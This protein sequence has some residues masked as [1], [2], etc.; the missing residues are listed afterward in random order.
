MQ[1]SMKATRHEIERLADLIDGTRRSL[2]WSMADLA[3]RSE[4]HES[5]VSRICRG[6]F[7]TFGGNVVQIC[8]ALNI[9]ATAPPL[10]GKAD[11]AGWALLEAA[12]R[13]AWDRT[14]EGAARLVKVIE[15]VAGIVGR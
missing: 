11:E 15:A 3:R 9:A 10:V 4:V 13:K 12:L 14:P 5:Q 2:N 7:R 6:D 1:I 8:K